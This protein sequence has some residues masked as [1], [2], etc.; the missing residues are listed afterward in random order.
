MGIECVDIIRDRVAKYSIDC[1]LRWGYCDVALKPRHMRWLEETLQ[2]ER[3]NNYPHLLKILNAEEIKSYVGSD[4][5]LG[6]MY[7]PSGA[8]H[9]HPINLC[10]GEAEAAQDQGAEIFEQSRIERID[11]GNSTTLHT[12]RGTI[13]AKK[14]ILCGNAYMENLVPKLA[15]RVLPASTCIVVTEPLSQRLANSILPKNVAV[16]DPRTALDY[17]RLTADRRLLFGGLSNYTGLVP[18]DYKNVMYKKMLRVYPQ[19]EGVSINFAWDGQMGIGINRTPQLGKIADNVYYIQ[20]YSGHGVAPT[21][22]MAK[23]MAE[24]INDET[25]RFNIMAKIRHWPFPGGRF[26]RRPGMAIGMLYFKALDFF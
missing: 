13:K 22:M 10:L 21:H 2:E 5:Y 9:I 11:Y 4:L 12:D 3:N 14:V 19:L 25:D 24:H 17:F 1:D 16:C 20:A 7:N 15:S 23:I 18:S 8:G 6:G 26:L